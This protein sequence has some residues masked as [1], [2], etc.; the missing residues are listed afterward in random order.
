MSLQYCRAIL[1]WHRHVCRVNVLCSQYHN[2]PMLVLHGERAC[3]KVLGSL[4]NEL[5]LP[6]EGRRSVISSTT[7]AEYVANSNKNPTVWN[8]GSKKG[9]KPCARQCRPTEETTWR[10]LLAGTRDESFDRRRM[11]QL[12]TRW[13]RRCRV[14]SAGFCLCNLHFSIATLTRGLRIIG[15]ALALWHFLGLRLQRL[16]C[17]AYCLRPGRPAV[18]GV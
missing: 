12:R 8:R 10:G 9:G 11:A 15:A 3:P 17:W 1:P 13:A 7:P 18:T 5:K 2:L 6:T 16:S 14:A 4:T